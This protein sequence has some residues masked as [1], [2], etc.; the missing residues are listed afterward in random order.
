MFKPHRFVP[1]SVA[2]A[3]LAAHGLVAHA[4]TAPFVV[5]DIRIEG[6]QRIEPGTVFSYLPIKQGD[7]FTDDKA[8]EAIRALYATGFFSD[9]RIAA[10]GDVVI[11]NVIERPAIGSID[12]AGL[13][14]FD[15]DALTKA[16]KGVGL[17]PGRYYDKSLVDR[18]EQELKRQYLTRG[19][20]A[21]EVTTTV[22]Q[23]DSSRVS[24]LFTVNEGPSAKIRQVNFIGNKAFSTATLRNEMQLSTPNWF[25][26]YTKNDLY[27]K[28]KLTG[29]L[30]NVR[31]FYLNRGY[32][33]F[34][35]ESTQVSISPDKKDMYLTLSVHEGEP[36]TVSSV[37]LA[38]NVL[39]RGPELQ[40]LVTVKP[41]ERFS[42]A[43]LQATTKAIVDKL[44]E[45][46]YAFATVNAQPEIDQ[47]H[48]KVALTL[49]VD[50]SRRVY[51]RR[52]NVV[53]N[54][55]TRDEVVRREMRQLESSWFD[56][57]RLALSKDRIN[58]LG[59]F[60]DVDVTTVPVAGTADQVDVNVKVTEKPTGAITLGAGF[61]STD[62]VVLSAGISQDNVFGSGTSLSVNVNTARTY[63]TLTVTQVDPYFTVDGIKRITDVYYRTTQPLYY[64]TNSSFR[65]ITAGGDLKFGIPFSEVDTVFFGAGFEQNKLDTDSSTPQS[66]V[67]YV[68][69]FGRVSNNIPLTIGWSRDAR[70]SALVPSR[71][72]FTQANAEYG[73]PVGATQY[74]KAD[75]QAQY[76]YSFA[77]G[78]VL[79]LN[80]Q[81]G[82]G[83][84]L[85]GKP[86]PIF[87]N[88]FAGGIGSVRGYEP[89]SLGPRDTSTNDPIGGSK[90]VVGNIEL[91]FP[92]PGTG[93]DR[94]LRV[95]TFFDGGNVWG[96]SAPGISTTG[97]NGLRYGYGVG[98]AW[99]SPIGP[100]KLSLGFPVQKHN[101]DQYQKFQFQIG[102]AF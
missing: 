14:E 70:D 47:V 32:L 89:S 52:I 83:N 93:Y 38:G 15:K 30:E 7:T 56:S 61:S 102:T 19:F 65:I 8:S 16:L 69:E 11:V 59:Y 41:G 71:G 81:G 6:L 35:I 67:N 75:V 25:S 45:Y 5:K 49:Q 54:T 57:S 91:T 98:L 87:K 22:T 64:S 95:F 23:I 28:D 26:W 46:G 94:T 88:Y 13:H 97:S 43:K 36:Y 3:A 17:S 78:F 24:I 72:Y 79:G 29:D 76:Y 10:E 60:T 62:K 27:S 53:G 50:P 99:I 68:N 40:K 58:R 21:A 48:H 73:T 90:M 92:L 31:S 2:V 66:Y 82:Y 42:A 33:E 18:S 39:D 34:N 55:R 51:V 85:G 4:A 12:F 9:V 100:L 101:G 84:G 74:Y 80:F 20:Y 96:Q 1:K 37:K 44:G 86:F 77:R 63:R